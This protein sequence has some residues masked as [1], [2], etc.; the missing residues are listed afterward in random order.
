MDRPVTVGVAGHVD[1]GKTT[2]VHRLTG[3]ATDRH[4]EERRRGLTIEAGVAPLGLASGRPCALIDV[5]GH[6]DFL[7]NAIRGLHGVDLALL[8]VAA[9]DGV[10]PQTRE[11]LEILRF[12]GARGGAVVLTKTDL[13]DAEILD[14]A[15]LEVA[16]LLGGTFLAGKPVLRFSARETQPPL[17]IVRSLEAEALSLGPGTGEA[18]FKLWIDQVRQVAGFGT[19]VSGTVTAGRLRVD[20]PVE[21]QPGGLRTRARSLESHGRPVVAAVAG[22]RV[23]ISLHR[24]PLAAV[25]RGMALT[26]PEALAAG[27]LLNVELEVLAHSDRPLQDR[28]RVKVYLGAASTPAL[29]VLMEAPELP[30]GA[31]GLAQLRLLQP[32]PASPREPLV[33]APLN[34]NTVVAGG[35]VLEVTAEKYRRAKHCRLAAYLHALVQDDVEAYLDARLDAQSLRPLTARELARDTFIPARRFEAAINARVHRGELVYFKGL[36]ALR[37]GHYRDLTAG[38]AAVVASLVRQ[39]PLRSPVPLAEISHHFPKALP[40]ELLRRAAEELCRTGGLNRRDAGFWPPVRKELATPASGL[41][42]ALLEFARQAGLTPFSADSVWKALAPSLP[43]KDIRRLLDVLTARRR[44]A[45]LGDNRYLDGAAV[46]TIKERVAR[47]I[48]AQGS[49]ALTDSAAILGYGRAGG[50]HVFDYLDRIG[51]TVRRGNQRVLHTPR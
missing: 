18:P 4:P 42:A 43:K 1:H 20:D 49:I 38:V 33:I 19:V 35:R 41:E 10:M 22:Q 12:F 9:D 40:P 13:V 21:L 37:P 27:Y 28:Q 3:V 45:R 36:G 48:E 31:R 14:L 23:G 39:D 5:P 26:A 17:E 30:P 2:L 34:R 51:F 29:A 44:L 11:H 6:T 25:G 8:V 16:D 7:K 15:E 24:V 50:A 32:L 46:E 47:A